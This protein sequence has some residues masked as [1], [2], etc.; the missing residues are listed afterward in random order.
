MHKYAAR[1][2]CPMAAG[3][4]IAT[5][6]P[7]LAPRPPRKGVVA[8][9]TSEY[10]III[11]EPKHEIQ[12]HFHGAAGTIPT[13]WQFA[14]SGLGRNGPRRN[15]IPSHRLKKLS[16][17]ST[18]AYKIILPSGR[19][20]HFKH[21]IR[22]QHT[23]TCHYQRTGSHTTY[24]GPHAHTECL[25]HIVAILRHTHTR[26]EMSWARTLIHTTEKHARPVQGT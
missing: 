8:I 5:A 11:K 9:V 24:T 17:Y 2:H 3:Q 25:R 1:R 4:G 23:R 20:W 26:T 18:V 13:S 15:I 16:S 21:T 10:L 22:R 14:K 19:N 12:T 7:L 6:K